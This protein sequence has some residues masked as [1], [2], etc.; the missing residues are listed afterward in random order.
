MVIFIEWIYENKTFAETV[1]AES[2]EEAKQ[3]FRK[4]NA[5]RILNI[6]KTKRKPGYYSEYRNC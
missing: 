6:R 4:K 2:I 1:E 5:G 3:M